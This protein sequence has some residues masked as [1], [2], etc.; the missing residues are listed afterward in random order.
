MQSNL[1]VVRDVTPD[2]WS[3]IQAVAP[4]MHAARLFNVASPEQAMAI[5]LKG[6]E[7]GMGLTASFE[8][9]QVVEGRPALS[10]RGCLALIHNSPLCAG[11][12]IEDLV[13]PDGKPAGCRVWMKRSNGFE[14]TT[15]FTMDDAKRAGL[16]KPQSGWDKYPDKMC[17]WR[18]VGFCADTVFPDIIGGM[19][20]TDELGADLTE[21]GD[22]I[23][24]TWQAAP[25]PAATV[26]TPA[27]T[28]PVPP[29]HT[30]TVVPTLGELAA[31]YGAERVMAANGG[32]IPGT[33]EELT[34]VAAK[35]G[36]N[37]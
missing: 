28:E 22:T 19:K 1:P 29:T 18:A 12:K 8:L 20:R 5:M 4:A 23:D 3:M 15:T 7:L 21:S 31:Q 16:V 13:G 25:V 27:P 33:S 9:V 37:V 10:P 17:K 35:L 26:Q 6:H 2:K 36:S 24:G 32:K 14:Y 34:A 11:L 30:A